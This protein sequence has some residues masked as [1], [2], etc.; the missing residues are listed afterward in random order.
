MLRA[1]L[2]AVE[3]RC[4]LLS[5]IVD[6]VAGAQCRALGQ[7]GSMDIRQV[8]VIEASSLA[9]TLSS[10]LPDPD[11]RPPS[12]LARYTASKFYRNSF[13]DLGRAWCWRTLHSSSQLLTPPLTRQEHNE[14]WTGGG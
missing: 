14:L 3:R 9:R 13:L 8:T 1:L 6:V 5:G 7:L 11:C 4:G 10:H 12:I 2:R